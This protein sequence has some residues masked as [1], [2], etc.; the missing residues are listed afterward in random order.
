M[1]P[2]AFAGLVFGC[3]GLGSLGRSLKAFGQSH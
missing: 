1:G 3:D 2:L